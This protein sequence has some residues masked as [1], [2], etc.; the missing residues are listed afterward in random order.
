MMI[1]NFIKWVRFKFNVVVELIN[2]GVLVCLIK[3]RY[4]LICCSELNIENLLV[5]CGFDLIVCGCCIYGLMIMFIMIFLNY[6]VDWFN[7]N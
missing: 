4:L 5:L 3:I 7:Y 1:F 2:F 6:L